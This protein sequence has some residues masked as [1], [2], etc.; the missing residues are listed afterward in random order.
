MPVIRISKGAF[1]AERH[2]RIRSMLDASQRSLV[3][4]IQALAGCLHF[5]AGID[6]VTNTMVNVSVWTTLEDAKQLDTLAPM[7]ALAGEFIAAGV[8]FERPITNYEGLWQV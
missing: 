3:P 2:D 5:W 7:L 8:Q 6:P 4:A 1:P